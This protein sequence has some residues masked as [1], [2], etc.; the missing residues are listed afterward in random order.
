MSFGMSEVSWVELNI[1]V[2]WWDKE[3]ITLS[4]PQL[5]DDTRISLV[6]TEI[7]FTFL[8]IVKYEEW[9]LCWI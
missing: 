7:L 5:V 9:L 3:N 1:F 8:I 2:H 4:F 6:F